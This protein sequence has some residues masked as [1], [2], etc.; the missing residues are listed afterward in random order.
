MVRY[1][2]IVNGRVQGVGFR[3]FANS[4]AIRYGLTGLVQNQNNGSVKMEIQGSEASAKI[5]LQM[6]Q[7]GNRFIVV[8]H[9]EQVKIPLVSDESAFRVIY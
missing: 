9:M 4:Y 6:I 8:E 1:S 5:F 3:F 2:I 7:E